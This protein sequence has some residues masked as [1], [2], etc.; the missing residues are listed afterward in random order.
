MWEKIILTILS[1][2]DLALFLVDINFS[3]EI[4]SIGLGTTLPASIF[5][6]LTI[7]EYFRNSR[8]YVAIGLAIVNLT[9][10]AI[11]YHIIN[12]VD[13][14]ISILSSNLGHI[15]LGKIFVGLSSMGVYSYGLYKR[16]QYA[17]HSEI[18]SYF[19]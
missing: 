19:D 2:L 7:S 18:L 6:G 13:S 9:I 11:I 14:D 4:F 15:T 5:V 1:I 8:Y 16:R 17:Y 10:F 12:L 3:I